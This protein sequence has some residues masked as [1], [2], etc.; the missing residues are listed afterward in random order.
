MAVGKL[1]RVRLATA[2]GIGNT[3]PAL[4]L[5][6][7]IVALPDLDKVEVEGR[8][9][10]WVSARAVTHSTRPPLATVSPSRL[11][12][13]AWNT[14]ASSVSAGR[15]RITSPLRGSIG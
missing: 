11:A 6:S 12:V 8:I 7:A 1:V 15:P 14:T 9:T 2:P 3:W 4:S 10:S 5:A 13:P